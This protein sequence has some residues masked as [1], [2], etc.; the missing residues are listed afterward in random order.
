MNI[1]AT[2]KYWKYL[3][4]LGPAIVLM[5][6]SA[7]V[8]SG[9]W[10]PVPLGLITAGIVT[11]GLWLLFQA[12]ESNWWGRRST[13]AGTNAL[14]ATLSVLVILGLINFLGTRYP[15][16]VDFTETQMFTLAPESGQLVRNLPQ[17]VK[18]WVFDRNQ[19]AQ[20]RELL[21]NY[22]RQGSQ[23]S[24]EYVDPEAQPGLAQKFGVKNFGEVY[25]EEA[26]RR[27]LLQAVNEQERLSEVKLTNGLQQLT[28]DYTAKV[29]FLQGH[30]EHPL[31]AGEGAISQA[32]KA[33]GEKN[34]TTEPLNLVQQL[35]PKDATVVVVAGPTRTLFEQEAKA[36]RDYLNQGGSLLLMLD[37]DTNLGFDLLKDW[38]VTL[39]N[40]LAI[41]PSGGSVG[42]GPAVALVTNYSP[43][44]ITKD[45][46]NGIS[47][48]RGARPIEVAPVVGVQVEPLLLTSPQSWA[49]SDLDQDLQFN[50]ERDRQGPLTLGVALTR[51]VKAPLEPQAGTKSSPSPQATPSPSPI[52]SPAKSSPSPQATPSPL[53]TNSPAKPAESRLVV[54]GN[55]DFATDGVFDQQ[56]NGDVFLNSVRWLSKQDDQLLSIRPKEAKN[57]RI[58]MTP[59]QASV[60][61]WT[62]LL[63]L[64]LLGFGAAGIL[65][66]KRR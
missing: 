31:S 18:V 53:P 40:R 24:F 55:S 14:V 65:W 64:P 66:W 11:T 52:N 43:H 56:L 30:G 32:L 51:Q 26:G 8:V 59:Q 45:F 58:N 9:T 29:Y 50:P 39:D 10:E 54:F 7:R 47:F 28:S 2:K 23:F 15:V 49:E 37:P 44:P 19:N 42:L 1:I 38:G 6:L 60:L 16:R 17:A 27:Q 62:S 22:Q 13:Q 34:Y 4:W 21:E 61:S 63:L 20:D 41:D 3:F 33:L 48:Y 57:R 35:V 12:R 36:L 46:G 5:G 25:L